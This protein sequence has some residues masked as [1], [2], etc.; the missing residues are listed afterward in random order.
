MARCEDDGGR[1][2]DDRAATGASA[3]VGNGEGRETGGNGVSRASGCDVE[4]SR[5]PGCGRQASDVVASSGACAESLLCLLA[6]GGRREGGG[7]GLGRAV[8]DQHRSWAGSGGLH[9]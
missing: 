9:G 1:G 5:R 6:R 8:L 2:Y 4:A 7:G 3:M